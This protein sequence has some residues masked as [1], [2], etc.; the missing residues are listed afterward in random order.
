MKTQANSLKISPFP[1]IISPKLFGSLWSNSCVQFLVIISCFAFHYSMATA[2]AG[3]WVWVNINFEKRFLNSPRKGHPP[4]DGNLEKFAFSFAF[5]LR[6][7]NVT[8]FSFC[9]TF[10]LL[11]PGNVTFSTSYQRW[12]IRQWLLVSAPYLWLVPSFIFSPT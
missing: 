7:Q 11:L 10:K 1:M 2:S 9:C 8:D 3:S 4:P 5:N 12:L 6:K